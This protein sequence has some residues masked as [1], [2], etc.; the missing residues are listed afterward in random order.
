MSYKVDLKRNIRALPKMMESEQG[1][2]ILAIERQIRLDMAK[3]AKSIYNIAKNEKHPLNWFIDPRVYTNKI[4]PAEKMIS[5]ILDLYGVEY[6]RE[7]SFYGLQ[8]PTGGYPRYDFLIEVPGGIHLCEYDGVMAHSTP[9]Q[10]VK[11][12][13]KTKFCEKYNIP[14]T[15][16]NKNH[17]YNLN[18]CI[19]ELLF[20]YKMIKG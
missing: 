15:R 3:A 11:D 8:L 14:L 16:W 13:L 18:K 17:Y 20:S 1:R 7:V 12:E 19:T 5:D 4:S 2:A 9:E 10:M 6:F